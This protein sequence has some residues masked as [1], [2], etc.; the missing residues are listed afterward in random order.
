M[1]DV[2]LVDRAEGVATL[3]LNRPESMNSLS[4]ELKEAL[5]DATRDVS[6]DPSVRAV[7][8]AGSGRGFCVGQDLR[9]HVSL[10]EAQDP[11][12]L[13]TVTEHYNPLVL[14]LARMPKPVIAAV[15]GMAAGAGAG[16]AFACDFRI[17]AKTAGFLIAFANVGLTLDS[18]V[19]W[20]LQRLVG[21]GR[22]TALSLLAEPIT[23]E[24]ALEM[25]L[26]NAV[27]E[28]ERVLPAA[29]ELA[30]RLAAGPTAAYAAIKQ[31]ISYAASS[32]LEGALALEGELQVAAG[33]TADHRNAT[34]AFVAKQK[35]TFTGR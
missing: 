6:G 1:T 18:G 5:L 23:A 11:S 4:I 31:S 3:T 22:A 12:P 21:L 15:N 9:E 13:S 32:D 16:L 20:T 25:A 30:A 28:P 14:T 17:A 7:V 34:A 24:A 8:L 2:L 29:Q 33:R 10:L 26:V 19:S 35:P 27:V